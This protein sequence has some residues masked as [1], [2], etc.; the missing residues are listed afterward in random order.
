MMHCKLDRDVE[1]DKIVFQNELLLH[2]LEKVEQQNI[3][4][5][6]D[7]SISQETM[8]SKEKEWIEKKRNTKRNCMYQ[9]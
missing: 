7:V 9:R 6:K 1:I 5:N 3:D 8:K 2:Q 4:D